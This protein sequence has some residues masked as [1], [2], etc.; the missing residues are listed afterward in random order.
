M[1]FARIIV[2][3]PPLLLVS[4]CAGR[5]GTRAGATPTTA[6]PRLSQEQTFS[7][8]NVTLK[9]PPPEATPN[10]SEDAIK[11]KSDSSFDPSLGTSEEL[12]LADYSDLQRQDAFAWIVH[13]SRACTNTGDAECRNDI[14]TYFAWNANTGD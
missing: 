7:D 14:D 8:V 11:E 2:L 6:P 12:Y 3:V 1:K 13:Y 10:W 5:L 4:G 9:P